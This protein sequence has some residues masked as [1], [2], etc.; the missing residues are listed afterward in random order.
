MAQSTIPTMVPQLDPGFLNGHP[1]EPADRERAVN[2]LRLL[3]GAR[4]FL[5]RV[6]A[7]G[8]F[9][10]LVTAFLLP[11]RYEST[12]QIMPPDAQSLSGMGMAATMARAS[13]ALGATALDL[14]G[15]KD[16]GS[17]F[18]SILQSRT[19][20]DRLIDRFNLMRVYGYSYR[21]DARKKLSERTAIGEDRKSGVISLTVTDQDP[22]RA[23]ALAHAYIDE[24][25]DLSA[26]LN[27]SAAHRE[28]VFIEER[29]KTVKQDLD[30]ASKDFSEFASKNTAIDI[31]EQGKAMVD[32]AATLQGQLIAA[33]SELQGLEQI[34]AEGNV[35]VRSVK[36]RVD[37]L[38]R[39]LEKLG[40]TDASL[41]P[42]SAQSGPAEMYPSIRK[43]PLLGVQYADLYQKTKIQE[44]VYELLTQQYEMAKIQEAREIPS[45]KVLDEAEIPE[46]KSFPP[47]LL[48]S[49]LGPVVFVAFA[50]VWILAKDKWE[51]VD[52]LN[53]WKNFVQELS[54]NLRSDS[55]WLWARKRHLPRDLVIG[56]FGWLR[57]SNGRH[58]DGS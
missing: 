10:S 38:K 39:Q 22:R 57:S 14:L 11:K 18:I 27:T 44:T 32:A 8:L 4:V 23:A 51:T 6:A 12:T 3:W 25:N 19:V 31:K 47:R 13:G 9:L 58:G 26:E 37:E 30:Q 53:P 41:L 40:G 55:R 16:S 46:K 7:W 28:R 50:C 45:V 21:K 15:T 29:L 56:V 20:Q 5:F 2:R 49:I 35:R 48:I 42:N 43:L 33:Q 54:A 1:Q 52:Q 24:L 36:A 17:T 34:Y